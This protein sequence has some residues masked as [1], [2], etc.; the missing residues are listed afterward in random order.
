MCNHTAKFS[1]RQNLCSQLRSL[2]ASGWQPCNC[3][4]C[5][6]SQ[7]WRAERNVC[8]NDILPQGLVHKHIPA[9]ATDNLC[10]FYSVC[11]LHVSAPTGHQLKHNNN[12]YIFMKNQHTTAHP[13]FY[14]YSRLWCTS[15]IIYLSILQSYNGNL[16]LHGLSPLVNYTDRATAACQRSDCQLLQIEDATSSGWQIPTAVFSVF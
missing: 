11:S 10:L 1:T 13:L 2:C 15:L 4:E 16:E 12:N 3:G 7:L 6:D 8:W 5:R 9:I 14:N